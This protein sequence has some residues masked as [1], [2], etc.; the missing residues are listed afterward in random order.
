[1]RCATL[2]PN[3]V[4][5][6]QE[7]EVVGVGII[8]DQKETRECISF[9]INR[10]PGFEYRHVYESMEAALDGIGTDPPRVVLVDIGLPGLSGIEGVRLL[11][12]RHPRSHP[13]F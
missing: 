3:H 12:Q 1:M 6:D 4:A 5:P 9:L 13:S 11:R 8:E 7:T 10:T 2:K